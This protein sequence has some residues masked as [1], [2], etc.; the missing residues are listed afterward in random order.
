[1]AKGRDETVP[2]FFALV[3]WDNHEGQS[4]KFFPGPVRPA[5]FCPGPGH[6]GHKK[7]RD[8]SERL[9]LLTYCQVDGVN[10]LDFEVKI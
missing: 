5:D 8:R 1:M 2:R 3:P 9:S 10:C 6:T 7:R 4:R